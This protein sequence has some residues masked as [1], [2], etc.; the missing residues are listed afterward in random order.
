[1]KIKLITV[2]Q[3]LIHNPIWFFFPYNKNNK[4]H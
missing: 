3:F 4:M 2:C 1:M